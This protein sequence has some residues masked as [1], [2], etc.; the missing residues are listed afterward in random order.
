[1]PTCNIAL[2]DKDEIIRVVTLHYLLFRVSLETEQFTK[3]LKETLNFGHILQV[4]T[5]Q[6]LLNGC[7]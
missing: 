3:G 1:M 4:R 2:K 5:I 6:I 7:E